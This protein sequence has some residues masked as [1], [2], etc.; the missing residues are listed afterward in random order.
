MFAP[1]PPSALDPEASAVVGAT[2][3]ANRGP[4][5]SV[6]VAMS[7]IPPGSSTTRKVAGR[8][9]NGARTAAAGIALPGRFVAALGGEASGVLV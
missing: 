8:S 9:R 2:V 1:T 4:V 6:R 5:S 7:A 3:I